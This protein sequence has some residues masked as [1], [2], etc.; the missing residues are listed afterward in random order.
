MAALTF[1]LAIRLGLLK[2]RGKEF[3]VKSLKV[4]GGAEGEKCGRN[5]NKDSVYELGGGMKA[6]TS[7]S[8]S[9]LHTKLFLHRIT[10]LWPI[11]AISC[12]LQT[13]ARFM[14]LEND[15]D[16]NSQD[17]KFYENLQILPFYLY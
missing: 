7:A 11:L 13:I 16:K 15:S 12:C 3:G 9:K 14:R 17:M 6:P 10:W 2:H 8:A 4:L 5:R 1:A